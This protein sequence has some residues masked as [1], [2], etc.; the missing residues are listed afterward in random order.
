MYYTNIEFL[1]A[2]FIFVGFIFF[3][4]NWIDVNNFYEY[5]FGS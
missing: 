5:F 3:S 2:A 1:N 4:I